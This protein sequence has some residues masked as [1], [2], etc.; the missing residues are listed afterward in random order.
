MY[1][2]PGGSNEAKVAL[3]AAVTAERLWQQTGAPRAAPPFAR[4]PCSP[5]TEHHG[6]N[7]QERM[8]VTPSPA[9][10]RYHLI[11]SRMYGGCVV[12]LKM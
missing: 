4:P 12:V 7:T 1:P 8:E 5:R 10:R 9:V 11:F 6:W 3:R 2:R